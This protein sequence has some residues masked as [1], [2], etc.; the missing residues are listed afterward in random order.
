MKYGGDLPFVETLEELLA[1]PLVV[2]AAP[3]YDYT[4]PVMRYV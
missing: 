4:F 3:D 1:E 2:L